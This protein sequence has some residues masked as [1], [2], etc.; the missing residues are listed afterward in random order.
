MSVRPHVTRRRRVELAIDADLAEWLAAQVG[1]GRRFRTMDE[2][3][4][5]VLASLRDRGN[6]G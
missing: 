6:G 3:V 1:P 4:G 2:A 5:A